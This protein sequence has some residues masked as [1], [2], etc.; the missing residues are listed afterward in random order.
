MRRRAG[1]A[2][3]DS[4]G[5]RPSA[6]TLLELVL[7]LAIITV[8]AAIA[9][10]R[11][12]AAQQNF[13]AD[14]AARRIVADLGLARSRARS[15]SNSQ[16]VVFNLATSQYQMPG[17]PDL[18]N[19]ANTYTVLLGGAPYQARLVSVDFGGSSQVTFDG[20]GVPDR[21]G[22]LVISAGGVQRTIVLEATSGKANV[23]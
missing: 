11:Y 8:L 9:V 14:A 20:Y 4:M 2:L 18:K 22:T 21:G 15:Q 16:T 3:G 13:R 19:P 10:P 12:T 17:A 5:K 23:Q 6:F 1:Q 7:V